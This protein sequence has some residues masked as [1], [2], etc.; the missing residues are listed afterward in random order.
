M[1]SIDSDMDL[2][3]LVAEC[4]EEVKG[5]CVISSGKDAEW[6]GG[7]DMADVVKLVGATIVVNKDFFTR[8]VMPEVKKMMNMVTP[9][10]T[11]VTS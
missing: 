11:G 9:D 2:F 7:L 6:V 3:A 10:S 8:H 1:G 5:I 4:S